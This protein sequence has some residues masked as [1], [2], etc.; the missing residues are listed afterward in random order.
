MV[1]EQR[2]REIVREELAELLRADQPAVMIKL[3]PTVVIDA[4]EFTERLTNQLT[5][6][7]MPKNHGV[8]F[9]L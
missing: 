1:D 4:S 2:V 7:K 9:L 8:R 5:L 6:S 3:A